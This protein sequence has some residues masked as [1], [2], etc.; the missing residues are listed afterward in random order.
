MKRNDAVQGISMVSVQII[1]Y[2]LIDRVYYSVLIEG[3]GMIL[4]S[5]DVDYRIS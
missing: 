4:K 1:F 3:G 2:I 5:K